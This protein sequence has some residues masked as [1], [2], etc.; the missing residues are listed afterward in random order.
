MVN[1]KCG[2]PGVVQKRDRVYPRDELCRARFRLLVHDNY[3]A[4]QG[5]VRALAGNK[6]SGSIESVYSRNEAG[7]SGRKRNDYSK[8]HFIPGRRMPAARERSGTH[9]DVGGILSASV[10][11]EKNLG[12]LLAWFSDN[13]Q[14]DAS[15]INR[16]L[17]RLE[18]R[19]CRLEGEQ[20]K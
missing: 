14:R 4:M 8:N 10:L 20:R 6:G 2:Q 3:P 12:E 18:Q 16:K 13:L 5:N 17:N 11:A 9:N 7:I 15:Y 19:I 1:A